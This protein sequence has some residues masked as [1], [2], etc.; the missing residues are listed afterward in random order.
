MKAEEKLKESISTY[1]ILQHPKIIFRF[2]IGAD[3]NLPIGLAKKTKK[4]HKHKKGYPD[5]FIAQTNKMY[6]GLFIEIKTD[7]DNIYKKNGKLRNT[8]HI[9]EQYSCLQEL[10]AR[11]YY[12]VFGCGVDEIINIIEDYLKK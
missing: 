8:P 11:G 7:F 1:L 10:N 3:I 4:I 5:L 9:R 2:D 12:A 6:S